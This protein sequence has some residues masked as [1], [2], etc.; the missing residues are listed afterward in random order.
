M[1]YEMND[2]KTIDDVIKYL[3]QFKKPY[4]ALEGSRTITH[5]AAEKM[6]KIAKILV[7]ALPN[8]I[9]RSAMQKGLTLHGQGVSI[10]LPRKSLNYLSHRKMC[11]K[12]TS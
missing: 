7:T 4:V 2:F 12:K 1:A 11:R 6:E 3:G 8:L 5:E 9:V 10:Q